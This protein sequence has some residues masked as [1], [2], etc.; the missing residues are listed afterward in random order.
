MLDFILFKLDHQ[1]L[2][3]IFC[4]VYPGTLGLGMGRESFS[5]FEGRLNFDGLN[6]ADAFNL[7]V[8]FEGGPGQYPEITEVIENP[9]GKCDGPFLA[10]AGT[11]EDGKKLYITQ[12]GSTYAFEAFPR[13]IFRGHFT[14][15]TESV[16]IG[17]G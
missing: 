11:K 8:F 3:H 6:L 9:L 7:L 14:Y 12:G 4:V 13:A 15:R 2:G 16:W 10:G 17:M 1:E 5:K